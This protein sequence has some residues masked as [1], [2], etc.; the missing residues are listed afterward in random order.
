M[1]IKKKILLE[2]N[3]LLVVVCT[4]DDDDGMMMDAAADRYKFNQH[5]FGF[6][7]N[8]ILQKR[9]TRKHFFQ[10]KFE[11]IFRTFVRNEKEIIYPYNSARNH[12]K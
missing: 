1:K 9:K 10:D 5:F 8:E 7:Q 12:I 2:P 4:Y 3:F 11:T 6:N